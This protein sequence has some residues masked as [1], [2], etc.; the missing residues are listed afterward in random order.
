MYRVRFIMMEYVLVHEW[1]YLCIIVIACVDDLM[2]YDS[3]F[4][5]Y[6]V[7]HDSFVCACNH[8]AGDLLFWTIRN[9]VISGSF[10]C[11]CSE[12]SVVYLL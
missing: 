6:V 9:G 11:P 12:S 4:T 3:R 1:S 2:C 5:E 8:Y 10:C 7:T